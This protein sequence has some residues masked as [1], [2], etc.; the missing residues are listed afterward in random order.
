MAKPL[1]PRFVFVC[2]ETFYLERRT[3]GLTRK[4][5]AAFLGVTVRTIR[6]WENGSS[7]IPYPA[8]KLIRMRA[9]G[10]VQAPGWEGWRFG[11]G[12]ALYSPCGRS[13]LSCQYIQVSEAGEPHGSPPRLDPVEVPA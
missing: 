1:R 8:F 2:R 13:F 3:A 7:R 4:E 11:R 10:V 9:G 12:G 6:N 5:A